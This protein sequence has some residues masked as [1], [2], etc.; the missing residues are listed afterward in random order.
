[1]AEL[2]THRFAS[3]AERDGKTVSVVECGSTEV[4][5]VAYFPEN[6]T[7]PACRVIDAEA[8]AYFEKDERER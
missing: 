7:C 5:A 8:Q 2:V 6:V 1:M 4:N 3:H